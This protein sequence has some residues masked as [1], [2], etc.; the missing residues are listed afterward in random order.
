MSNSEAL[1][2]QF[3]M[4]ATIGRNLQEFLDPYGTDLAPPAR[5]LEIDPNDFQNL[6]ARISLDRFCRLMEL[7]ATVTRDDCF[8]LKY[9]QYFKIGGTGPFGY[10][11]NNAPSFRA[12][13]RF[14]VKFVGISADLDVLNL[15]TDNDRIVIQW[16]ISPLVMRPQQFCDFSASIIMRQLQQAAGIEIRPMRA[17]FERSAPQDKSFHSQ[18]F[19]RQIKFGAEQNQVELPAA[20]LERTNPSADAV[21]FELMTKQ[22]EEIVQALKSEKGI[23][24]RVKEDLV[25]HLSNGD[26]SILSVASRLALSERT[27]QRRLEK[28]G[29]TFHEL[30]TETRSELSLRLL[31]ETDLPLSEISRKLGY[32]APSAYTRAATR[33]HGKAPNLLR[34]QTT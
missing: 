23:I 29:K 18:Y 34:K 24:T 5:S 4:A 32:S 28:S 10:G 3:R 15:F 30:Y 13:L 7:L 33:W 19:C 2:D 14:L 6:Q 12:A 25:N 11:L 21:L 26:T 1:V 20:L 8:G 27:L 22:C 16:N 9:G 31:K 17:E